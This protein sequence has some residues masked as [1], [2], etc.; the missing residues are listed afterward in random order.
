MKDRVPLYP[1]RVELTPVA[2]QE[3]TFDMTRA[4][5]PQVEGTPLNKANLLADDTATSMGLDPET[6]TPNDMLAQM[7]LLSNNY[8]WHK[9]KQNTTYSIKRTVANT[10]LNSVS[11]YNEYYAKYTYGTGYTIS[12][13]G[14]LTLTGIFVP[15]SGPDTNTK[16]YWEGLLTFYV[17]KTNNVIYECTTIASESEISL[18]FSGFT[19]STEGTT[20]VTDGG[21]VNSPIS[22][23]YPPPA[24]DGW[25]YEGGHL[26]GDRVRITYGSFVGAGGYNRTLTFNGKPIFLVIG[27]TLYSNSPMLSCIGMSKIGFT[28]ATSSSQYFDIQWRENSVYISNYWYDGQSLFD[29]SGW[30]YAYFAILE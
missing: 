25:T 20:T 26:F 30:E 2:G 23:A 12:A 7:H 16:S 19:L 14:I 11:S 10:F 21:Y 28:N 24:D 1:G 15:T 27:T 3:N 6:A 4:D 18:K 22:D 5:S 13:D 29:K 8:V 9:L 17:Q